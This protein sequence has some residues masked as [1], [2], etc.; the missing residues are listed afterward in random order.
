MIVIIGSWIIHPKKLTLLVQKLFKSGYIFM[1]LK[2][3][4]LSLAVLFH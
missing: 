1:L 4:P 2:E 3:K